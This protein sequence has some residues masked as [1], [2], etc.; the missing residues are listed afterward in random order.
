MSNGKQPKVKCKGPNPA[1]QDLKFQ[2]RSW[3]EGENINQVR[4][5]NRKTEYIRF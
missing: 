2:L 1:D 4:M 5:Q 3:N